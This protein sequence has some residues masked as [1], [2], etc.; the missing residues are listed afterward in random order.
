M[1]LLLMV[2][3]AASYAA[4][5]IFMKLTEGM[6]RPGWTALMFLGFLVG[7]AIQ[8]VAMKSE[9]MAVTYVIVL[10]LEGIIAATAGIWIFSEPLSAARLLGFALILGGT[11]VL[12]AS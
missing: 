10:G 6:T 2:A 11:A 1:Q 8:A 3:A 4:G 9:E 7:A 5:G 12:R